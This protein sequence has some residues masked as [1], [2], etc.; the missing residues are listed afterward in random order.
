MPSARKLQKSS[1]TRLFSIEDRANPPNHPN[2]QALARALGLS[3]PQ[4]DVTPIRVPDPSQYGKF[5]T[6]DRIKGQPG[7]PAISI[8]GRLTRELSEFLTLVRKGCAFD[9]QLH[10]GVCEDP[11]DFNNG[12]EKIY[13]LEG[14]EATSYDTA[15]FG[16]LDG[17]QDAVV[18]ETI[19]LVGL[20][21]YELKRL[22]GTELGAAAIVQEVVGVTICDSRQCGEC[23][24]SSNG[25]EKV[26]AV[27]LSSGGSPGLPAEVLFSG[28][29]GTTVEDTTIT[30]IGANE[31]PTGLACVG[32]YLVVISNDSES[33]HYAPLADILNGVE[34]WTE[35]ATGF[36]AAKGPNAIFSLGSVF[37]WI[38]GDGGYI[39]FSDD[40]TAGVEVQSAGSVSSENLLDIHGIDELNLVVVGEN[41]TVLV[42]NN[43]GLTWAAI[44]GPSG[45]DDLN[46]VWMKSELIWLVG[47]AAGELWYTRDGGDN[48][49]IK[50]FSGS[51]AGSVR[52]IQFSTPTVGYMSHTS[53]AGNG[54][55]FRTIDGGFSW[56]ILPEAAG[57]SITANHGIDSLAA[58][59]EDPNL[60]FG[61]GLAADDAD[62]VMVKFA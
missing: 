2:Y 30:S 5:I 43:G 17:D 13:V 25:C 53:G 22:L 26:F 35:I 61:G 14:A 9:M 52:D 7:L 16:A 31:D 29:S 19:P 24:I 45:G 37:T 49:T 48:W 8:E 15:E 34:V 38:V 28:D 58:C 36:V 40:I 55:I 56:Y 59:S 42:T 60:V 3:W 18:N 27:T 33:A 62:G 57:F 12:W 20:D 46:A 4:G 11:R 47:T 32:T 1:Q 21:W 6:V 39:Y 54:R 10:A 41:N 44:T 50:S 51:G 23:G